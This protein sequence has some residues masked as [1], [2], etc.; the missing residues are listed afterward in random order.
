MEVLMH[1]TVPNPPR[2]AFGVPGDLDIRTG[3]YG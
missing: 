2:L 3:G 1:K